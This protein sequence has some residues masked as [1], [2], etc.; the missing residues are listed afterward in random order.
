[1]MADDKRKD[2]QNDTSDVK[3]DENIFE[4]HILYMD[5]DERD[6]DRDPYYTIMIID[7]E[8]TYHKP[9]DADLDGMTDEEAESYLES[10]PDETET[11]H[12]DEMYVAK[13]TLYTDYD[14]TGEINDIF[15][16][17]DPEDALY[18]SDLDFMI[19]LSEQLQAEQGFENYIIEI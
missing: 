12:E 13:S 8:A 4:P 6:D 10:I 7:V 19:Y 9:V 5:D 15:L 1:M 11:K 2:K 16:T 3:D 18:V 17:A 14:E